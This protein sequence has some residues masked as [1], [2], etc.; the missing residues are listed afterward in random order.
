MLPSVL[1]SEIA[2]T[3]LITAPVATAPTGSR[4]CCENTPTVV[5]TY[6]TPTIRSLA[7]IGSTILTLRS[8]SVNTIIPPRF[9]IDSARSSSVAISMRAAHTGSSIRA[10]MR[11][12]PSATM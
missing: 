10:S 7:I 5:A 2:S 4:P 8:S 3:A 11:A 9:T 1:C 6:A 12:V